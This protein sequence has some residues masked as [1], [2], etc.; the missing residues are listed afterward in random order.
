CHTDALQARRLHRLQ[1][2]FIE[3]DH[4]SP[5]C[6]KSGNCQLQALAQRTGMTDLHYGRRRCDDAE[7]PG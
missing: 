3:G 4:F 2:L 5:C 7:T 1:M 6:E